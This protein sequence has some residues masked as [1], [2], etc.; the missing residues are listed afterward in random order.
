MNRIARNDSLVPER[1]HDYKN[2]ISFRNALIH[3]YELIDNCEVWEVI[4]NNVP[5]L[6]TQVK[7]LLRDVE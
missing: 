7:E 4:Q 3:G 5:A 6:K 1:I 2:I